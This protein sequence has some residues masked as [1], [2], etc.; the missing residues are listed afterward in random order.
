[1]AAAEFCSYEI[2]RLSRCFFSCNILL[3]RLE[4]LANIGTLLRSSIFFLFSEYETTIDQ[5]RSQSPRY[6]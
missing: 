2:T 5:S 3:S 4:S 1:M 6:P